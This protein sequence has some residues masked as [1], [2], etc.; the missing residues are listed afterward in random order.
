V[1]TVFLLWLALP[2]SLTAQ[3]GHSDLQPGIDALLRDTPVIQKG[4]VGFKV[5]DLQTGQVIAQ[6][7]NAGFFTPASNV[8]LY[9]TA[10]ALSRL[11]PGYTFQTELRTSGP[12]RPA[13][14][15]LPDLQIIGA[16]DPNLSGRIVPYA[17]DSQPGDPLGPLKDLASKLCETGVTEINGDITGVATRYGTDPYPDGWTI[18]DS[19]YGYGAPVSSLVINDNVVSFSVSPSQAGELADIETNP[20]FDYFVILNQIATDTSDQTHIQITRPPGSNEVILSG[21]IG[22]RAPVWKEDLAIPDPALFAA[23]AL[24][25]SLREDALVVRGSPAAMYC[26]PDLSATL[27]NSCAPPGGTILAVHQSPPLAQAVQVVNKVSQNLHAEML[28]RETSLVVDGSGT[29][30]ASLSAREDF[31]KGIGVTPDNTGF[32]LADG[33]GLARQDLTTSD[34]TVALLQSMW[35]SP[36]H[37]VWLASLPVG[38]VDGS[39]QHRF[40][41]MIG[42]DHIHAKTGSLA[43]VSSLSG[44]IETQ[45]HGWLAF[46]I[47]VNAAVGHTAD[48]HNFIDSF[49]GLFLGY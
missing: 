26:S 47:M 43:H 36:V 3:N 28:L 19:L 22:E 40:H 44:Y 46:S 2:F 33:S 49:C 45:K 4:H 9:T 20:G 18:D 27:S 48:V 5:V 12:W 1:Q 41:N 30:E 29:L 16:G 32:S 25:E 31:L 6:E 14:P 34:S 10:F 39:L 11:G 17:V 23:E 38:G 15:A 24:I 35:Q 21:S 42:A 7:N 8:K 13:E 37:D